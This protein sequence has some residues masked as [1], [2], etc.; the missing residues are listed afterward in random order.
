MDESPSSPLLMFVAHRAAES[1][2]LDAVRAAGFDDVT[3]AQCRIAQ[4]L[5]RDGIRLTDLAEQAQVTKQTAGALVDELERNGY[6]SREPD[7]ADARARL[8]MLSERGMRVCRAAAAEIGRI[9]AGW[10][11]H[12]GDESYDQL[13][14]ALITL[15]ELTDPYR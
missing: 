10:R 4:R 6:V 11:T 12:L 13:R 14:R 7:P 1:Q 8:V 3:L 2:V 9:E 5:S 15:R